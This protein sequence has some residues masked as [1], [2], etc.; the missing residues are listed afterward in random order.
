[1]SLVDA[2]LVG[3]GLVARQVR[4]DAG[5]RGLHQSASVGRPLKLA[6]EICCHGGDGFARV[7]RGKLVRLGR[8]YGVVAADLRLALDESIRLK[9]LRGPRIGDVVEYE[10]I[11]SVV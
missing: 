5:E 6:E 7:E 11:Q 8:H 4:K 9:D 1:M 10:D 2:H 3:F